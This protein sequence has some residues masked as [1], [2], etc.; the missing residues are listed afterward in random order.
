M[1][2]G[3][4]VVYR[5]AKRGDRLALLLRY[6]SDLKATIRLDGQER[7]VQVAS[8]REIGDA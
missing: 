2:P 7:S 8:L 5:T 4:L 1:T 6:R 3:D